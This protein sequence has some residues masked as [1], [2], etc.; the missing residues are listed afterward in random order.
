MYVN[1]KKLASG[2][3][4]QYEI[5]KGLERE[6]YHLRDIGYIKV[7][8]IKAIP[9]SGENLSDHIE[10]TET[11]KMFVELRESVHP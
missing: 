2:N 11:G 6:L 5:S 8:S 7:T 9:K 4:G 1:L 10:V 3:F